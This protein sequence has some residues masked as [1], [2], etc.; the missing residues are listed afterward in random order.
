MTSP[1]F[2]VPTRVTVARALEEMNRLHI[3][4]LSVLEGGRVWG[5]HAAGGDRRALA[6]GMAEAQVED[7]LERGFWRF[8]PST[9]WRN[10]RRSLSG[11]ASIS[12]SASR[13]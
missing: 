11:E 12:S 3:N 7:I 8:V 1:V 9:P 4:A 10:A 2:T 13:T 6:H 5:R